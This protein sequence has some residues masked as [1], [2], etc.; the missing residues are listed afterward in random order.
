MF[1]YNVVFFIFAPSPSCSFFI[2]CALLRW[3]VFIIYCL[4][5]VLACVLYFLGLCAIFGTIIGARSEQIAAFPLFELHICP[6]F[7]LPPEKQ[8][9]NQYDDSLR[10]IN[11]KYLPLET[12]LTNEKKEI[13]R[14]LDSLKEKTQ[15]TDGDFY[16]GFLS[17]LLNRFVADIISG[18]RVN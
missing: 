2:F 5:W 16:G 4:N 17:N 1:P 6:F 9:K 14:K 7:Q 18:M 3:F 13:E 15:T 12:N 11:T 8:I 10:L